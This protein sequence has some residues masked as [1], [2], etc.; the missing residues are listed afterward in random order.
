MSWKILKNRE[1]FL[2]SKKILFKK[3]AI[4]H[5]KGDFSE[6]RGS[7]CN[8]PVETANICNILPMPAISNELIMVKV[9]RDLEYRRHVYFEPVRP[10]I[11]Y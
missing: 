7:I 10:R 2:I 5:G 3:I 8:I 1:K 4:I 9:K 11:V 6:I